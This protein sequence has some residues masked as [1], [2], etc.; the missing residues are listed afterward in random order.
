MIGIG[1]LRGDGAEAVHLD[2]RA[3]FTL[4]RCPALGVG[5][6]ERPRDD[7]RVPVGDGPAIVRA[8]GR[9]VVV[10]LAGRI[11]RERGR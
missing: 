10:A 11:E 7:I 5:D 1:R 3:P 8:D 4:G 9:G 6:R 2:V